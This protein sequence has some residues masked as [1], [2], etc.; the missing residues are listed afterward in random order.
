MRTGI[1]LSNL[2]TPDSPAVSDVR[3]YLAQFLWDP[4]VI[5]A[6]RPLWWCILNLVILPTRPRKS[7]RAYRR[8]WTRDGS[9]LLVESKRQ[10][11][12]LKGRLDGLPVELG[13]RYGNPSIRQ[14]LERLRNEGVNR[15]LVL[16]LY[17]QF[18]HTTTSSV[19]DE[20]KRI[21]AGFDDDCRYTL[22]R[23]YHDDSRYIS[24]LA[25]SIRQFQN[26]HGRPEKLLISFH[27]IPRDYV[28]AGDPYHDQCLA[29]GRLLAKALALKNDEWAITFQS[30]F[31]P[32]AWIQ[33]YTDRTL[34]K[35]GQSGV[36]SVQVVCPGFSADCLE[37]LEEIAMENRETFLNAGG[38]QYEY[39]PC[40]NS[41][42]AH[43]S[44]MQNLVEAHLG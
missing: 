36:S 6:P 10:A 22:I 29:T 13:M 41:S 21:L 9:P 23:D 17:P 20:V 44:L 7:A 3:R 43:I 4:R 34:E 12:L 5:Q 31:G 37:T 2:G 8:I 11:S 27:G 38:K 42:D 30:R 16:G 14:A 1:L 40:L 33:P 39:I 19:E 35:W 15:F 25:D 32:K 26:D 28:D 18:S 24:A